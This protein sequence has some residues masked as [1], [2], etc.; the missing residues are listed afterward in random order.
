M[1]AINENIYLITADLG[2]GV[3]E[4]FQQKFPER[5]FNVGVSE[6]HMISMAAGLAAVGK[7][8][9]CYSINNFASFRCAE[10]IRND[11]A[12]PNLDV[13]ILSLGP[14]LTYDNYGF[15]HYGIED[16]NVVENLPNIKIFEPILEESVR[17]I[18]EESGPKY[19]RVGNNFIKEYKKNKSDEYVIVSHGQLALDLIKEGVEVNIIENLTFSGDNL[20]KQ[21]EFFNDRYWSVYIASEHKPTL[22]FTEFKYGLQLSDYVYYFSLPQ[23]YSSQDK[24]KYSDRQHFLM[25][26]MKFINY[27]N[28]KQTA[29]E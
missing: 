23:D 2:Y 14:G 26:I 17:P 13:T 11:I 21:L 18:L 4:P 28:P 8:V 22:F 24:T 20:E 7:K 5:F 27:V 10:Q 6:Q 16:I 12:Y 15:S 19:V 25:K 29:E 3:L 1:A 9:F